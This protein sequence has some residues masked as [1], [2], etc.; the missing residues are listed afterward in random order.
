MDFLPKFHYSITCRT[1]ND[2]AVLY[3]LRGLAQWAACKAGVAYNQR[4]VAWGRTTDTGWRTRGRKATLRFVS[5]ESR[6]EFKNKAKEL[7][8]GLWDADA[9]S[10]NDPATLTRG[11]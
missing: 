6:D 2:L 8:P 5:P 7:L 4:A 1:T 10:D 11:R 3:C 9:E